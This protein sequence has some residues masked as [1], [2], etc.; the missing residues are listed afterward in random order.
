MILKVENKDDVAIAL[1]S[2]EHFAPFWEDIKPGVIAACGES[3]NEVSPETIYGMVAAGH[4]VCWVASTEES[5]LTGFAVGESIATEKG[6]YLNIPFAWV[7]RSLKAMNRLME[8]V[9]EYADENGFYG[10]KFL[11]SKK[12]FGSWA[13]RRGYKVRYIEYVRV[14]GERDG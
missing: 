6:A 1:L 11:S 10:V 5:R 13:T 4:W 9:E 8:S 2:G 3:H 14:I 7:D 12:Q